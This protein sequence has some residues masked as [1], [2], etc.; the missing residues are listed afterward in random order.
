MTSIDFNQLMKDAGEGFQPVPSGPY[1]AEVAKAEAVTSSTGKPMIKVQLRVIGGPHEGRL[2]FDQFVITAG[3]PNALSFF[4][5][6]MAA[7]GLDRSWFAQNPPMETVAATLMGRQVMVSV[8]I[9]Q[10]KGTDRN[11][12][13]SYRPMTGGQIGGVAQA[14]FGPGAVPPQAV[15]QVAAPAAVAAPA[16]APVPAPVAPAPA[17]VAPVPVA[18]APAP[19]PPVAAPVPPVAAPVPPVAAPVPAPVPPVA[20]VPP[21]A[22]VAAPVPPVAAP[23]PEAPVAPVAAEVPAAPV[24]PA[25]YSTADEEAF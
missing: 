24:P 16:P 25:A 19:V 18:P 5:E 4:F 3:N 1:N 8:G 23:V 14:G 7:F 17:P 20:V 9:K 22:A 10:F 11:E 15:P 13:Q 2:L 6:H 12:V 21:P